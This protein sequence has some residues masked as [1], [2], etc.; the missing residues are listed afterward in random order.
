MIGSESAGRPARSLHSFNSRK[1]V[2]G[3]SIVRVLLAVFLVCARPSVSVVSLSAPQGTERTSS[4]RRPS[5]AY[6]FRRSAAP[7]R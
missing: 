1:V 6:V 7:R 2:A 3:T 4:G 5:V